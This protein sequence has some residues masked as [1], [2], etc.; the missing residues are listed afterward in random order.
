MPASKLRA[1]ETVFL[2]TYIDR[3]RS[4]CEDHCL[5]AK[6][7]TKPKNQL[8]REICDDFYL[9]FPK[10]DPLLSDENPLTFSQE[11]LNG[12][13]KVHDVFMIRIFTSFHFQYVRQWLINKTQSV[14]GMEV[15]K[16][17]KQHGTTTARQLVMKECAEQLGQH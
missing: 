5:H 14:G 15:Q 2:A 4:L 8:I 9:K 10:H 11:E 6:G 3:W 13:T 16:L 7:G 17:R 12:F 1:E